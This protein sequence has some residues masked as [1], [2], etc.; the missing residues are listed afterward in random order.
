MESIKTGNIVP[1]PFLGGAVLII[2]I[3]VA[4]R[5]QY[6]A[7]Y[8]PISLYAWIGLLEAGALI[9]W[10]SFTI[11]TYGFTSYGLLAV[12]ILVLYILTNI[13][14]LACYTFIRKDRKYKIWLTDHVCGNTFIL[15]ISTILSFRFSRI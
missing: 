5:F 3:L 14:N 2:I 6:S 15:T 9:L 7:M 4:V 12:A 10:A 8:L 13:I 1:F 11:S